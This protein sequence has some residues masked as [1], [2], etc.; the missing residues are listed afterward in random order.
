MKR[1]FACLCGRSRYGSGLETRAFR[2]QWIR[3]KVLTSL[4]VVFA[5]VDNTL[6]RAQSPPPGPTQQIGRAALKMPV[7]LTQVPAALASDRARS[8]LILLAPDGAS[9][10]LTSQFHNASDADVSVDGKHILFAGQ[11]AAA[12]DWNVYEMDLRNM[13]TRQVTRTPGICR[14]PIYTSSFYTITEKEPWEQ[15]AFVGS[16][17]SP[18]RRAG[19]RAGD[20][21]LHLQARRLFPATHLLQPGERSRSSDHG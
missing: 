14:S 3:A 18:G 1:L 13:T 4:A 8:R 6:A 19:H 5:L 15:I 9:R 11:T 21:P 17:G 20:Q 10:I 12:G 7:V 2:S 16:A